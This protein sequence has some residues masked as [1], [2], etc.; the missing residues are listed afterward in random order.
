ME[1]ISA[2][3]LHSIYLIIFAIGLGVG[4]GSSLLWSALIFFAGEDNKISN[5]EFSVMKKTRA[6]IWFAFLLY[7]FGGVGL[8]TMAYESMLSLEIFYATMNIAGVLLLSE[9]IFTLHTIPHLKKAKEEM[10]G[11]IGVFFIAGGV[12]SVV[13]WLFLNVHHA[14][15]RT[16]ISYFFFLAI[17][18]L[19]ISFF[20]FIFSVLRKNFFDKKSGSLLRK[21]SFAIF[22]FSLLLFALS[23]MN[24]RILTIKET[25][26]KSETKPI[27]G[28]DV[29][30]FELV[31][32]HNNKDDCWLVI[33]SMVFDATEASKVHPAMFNC[34]TDASLNYH[35]N[36]GKGV[37]DKM[38]KFYIGTL[39]GAIV[40]DTKEEKSK[41]YESISPKKEIYL[42]DSSWDKRDLMVVVE[43]D[44]EN[45]LFID[46]KNH[47][48]VGRIYGVG[49]QPHT[50]VFS[51]DFKYMYII[52]RD[53]WLLKIDLDTLDTVK[54]VRVGQN[55]RGTALSNDG[56][57]LMIGNYEP[58][59]VVILDAKNLE[60]LSTIKTEGEKDGEIIGSRVGVVVESSNGFIIALKDVNSVWYIEQDTNKK[61][62]VKNK[63]S[64]IGNNKTPLHDGYLTPDGKFFIVAAQGADSVWVLDTEN[65]KEVGEVKTGTLPHTGP[66]A[67]FKNTTYIPSLGEGLI[68][69]IDTTTWKPIAS[70]KTGGPGLFVRS[71]HKDLEYHYVWAD[72]AFGDKKDEIYVIDATQNKIIKTLVPVKG[73]NSWHPEFTYDGKFVYVVSQEGGEVVVYDSRTFEVIKRIKAHTPSAVSNV[74]LRVE[75]PGL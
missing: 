41:S 27:S 23:F 33:D 59:N 57:F 35:K 26:N 25:V 3:T 70:I 19:C 45:L 75:E 50:S 5:D 67:T 6:V 63:Y 21:V 73:K 65:W 11:R 28:K 32:N 29:F 31:A 74:G 62:V 8:F 37:S 60:V 64:N 44:A 34:G 18:L 52:S 24:M 46:G 7:A 54:H 22:V 1:I 38:M 9:L 2:S 4:L 55:S 51:S 47:N 56:A 30:T 20:I 17:Y 43:K 68:T 42:K 13:S 72:T 49:F 36:H 16:E 40:Q 69:A 61:W 66:G 58:H 10:S 15:Y 12:V 39:G 71:Y 48:E 53:G 14:L